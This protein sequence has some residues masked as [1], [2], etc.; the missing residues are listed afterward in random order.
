MN[1]DCYSFE[2]GKLLMLTNQGPVPVADLVGDYSVPTYIYNLD[3]IKRRVDFFKSTFQGKIEIH[4]A[5]KCNDHP[6][7]LKHMAQ[8]GCGADIVSGGE[9]IKA[10][11]AGIPKE[12]IVFSGIGKTRKEIKLALKEEIG[13]LNVES[14]EELIRIGEIAKKEKTIAQVAFR[15]NPDVNPKTHPYIRT[16]FRD[17]KFGMDH[18]F[19][20]ELKE[21]LNK[22][23]KSLKLV[24]VTQHIGSQ[25]R[26]LSATFEA[27]EKSLSVWDSLKEQGFPL[28]S[29][30][31]GGGIGIDYNSLNTDSEFQQLSEYGSR[32]LKMIEDRPLRLMSEPGRILVGRSG[33]LVTEIQ[34]FK[35][36]PYKNFLIVDTGMHQLLRPSLYQAHH[37][38]L[39]LTSD[40]K[41]NSHKELF[42]V[43]GPI[44][45][46]SDVIGF[47]RAFSN[48]KA[49]DLLGIMDAGAYG[50]VM[51][52]SYNS[53]P[54]C[55]ELFFS[56]GV[57]L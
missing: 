55:K 8:W 6:I 15:L 20:A 40:Q 14:P 27:V 43:V 31:I 22:Y 28:L 37:Q 7:I 54:E 2:S 56:N 44:C 42:D 30:D 17:N 34:Y 5:V 50:A 13:Q 21:I 53:H 26:D 47:D 12:K 4:F 29:F 3:D 36:S 46:S 39:P 35:R 38:I 52:S 33:V 23:S 1:Q 48:L 32:I 18:S 25:L 19:F 11:E 10:L 24:G 45:E 16:G 41:N 9:L 57:A 51:R 49:G